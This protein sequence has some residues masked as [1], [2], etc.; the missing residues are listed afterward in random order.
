[1]KGYQVDGYYNTVSG[2]WGMLA[3]AKSYAYA[4]FL[5]NE[6]ALGYLN[7]SDGWSIGTDPSV[8]VV[9]S[10]VAKGMTWSSPAATAQAPA[11]SRPIQRKAIQVS[12]P[13]ST[14]VANSMNM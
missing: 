3:G 6:K 9:N 4:V 5:M 13:T 2:S 11:F 10:G 7:K 14:L 1:M 8:V 12:N